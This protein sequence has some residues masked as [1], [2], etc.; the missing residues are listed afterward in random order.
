MLF[1]FFSL[2]R[3]KLHFFREVRVVVL[4]C[5]LVSHS[6][7]SESELLY[8]WQ[9][10]ANQFVFARS[11]LRPKTK[12]FQLNTCVYSPYVTSSLTR[13]WVCLLQLLIVLA[14]AVIFLSESSGTHCHILLSQIRHSPNLEGQVPVFTSPRNRVARLYSRH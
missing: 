3:R 9:F 7:Q 13:G 11:P 1:T 8:D 14:S 12:F 2:P 5:C 10:T 6:R 4:D